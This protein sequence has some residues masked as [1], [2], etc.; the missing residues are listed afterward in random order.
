M[1]KDFKYKIFGLSAFGCSLLA[2]AFFT[3]FLA[4]TNMLP[5][6]GILFCVFAFILVELGILAFS[7]DSRKK[8]RTVAMAIFS[9]IIILIQIFGSYYLLVG[10]S[11]LEKITQVG[12]EKSEVGVYVRIDDPAESLKDTKN[13]TFGILEVQDRK[14]T[15]SALSSIGKILGKAVNTKSYSSVEELMRGLLDSKEV[16]AILLNKSFLELFS[17]IEGHEKDA[18]KIRE[19]YS[20]I[21]ESEKIVAAPKADKTVFSVY[22]SGIDCYGS[23]TRRSRSDVNIIATVNT[24]TGQILLVSTPRDYY[25]PLS[26]SNG[27]PDKLAHAGIYGIDVSRDTLAALYETDIDYHFRVNFDGFKDIVNALDGISVYSEYDFKDGSYSFKKGV[28]EL[29]GEQAL[30]FARNRYSFASGDRQRG[31]NQMAVV[32]AVINKAIGPAIIMNYKNILDSVAGSFDTNMPYDMITELI[33]TQIASQKKWNIVSYSVSGTGE[34]R[35]PYS[36][37]SNAYV[38]IPDE[39]TVD[40][41]KELINKVKN[42]KTVTQE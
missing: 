26:I 36:S 18:E 13:Y 8:I 28:N 32:K 41:A 23:I 39:E 40:H 38:M 14:I 31:K 4:S 37:S 19:L 10:R 3:Y 12:T 6:L 35:K 9:I 21:V 25:V 7:L 27:V 17:D 29:N 22:I 11:A 42:G 30:A 15:D 2:T 33:K 24:Q 5:V 20:V 16:Y 1:K 34:S